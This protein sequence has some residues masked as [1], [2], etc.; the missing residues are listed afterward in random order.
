LVKGRH[1]PNAVYTTKKGKKNM[2][3]QSVL[4]KCF[5]ERKS[6]LPN[7]QQLLGKKNAQKREIEE[8][9]RITRKAKS[10]QVC[11]SQML[12]K[13]QFWH[14]FPLVFHTAKPY[15]LVMQTWFHNFVSILRYLGVSIL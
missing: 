8:A 12:G 3:T 9:K 2:T 5:F 14:S 15:K 1:L 11:Y 10:K 4:P 13:I 7:L 6:V